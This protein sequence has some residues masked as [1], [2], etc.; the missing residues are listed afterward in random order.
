MLRFRVTARDSK[1]AARTGLLQLGRRV[2]PTP[3]FMPV[4]TLGTVKAVTTEELLELGCGIVLANTY[5][6]WQR[7]GVEVV[8]EHGGLHR[9]MGW[10]GAILTDSGG[11]QVFSLAELREVRP[12]GVE[13][14]SH[15]D[16][17]KLFLT[18][19]LA[20][21]LQR[22]LGSDIVMPLDECV[23]L[24]ADAQTVRRS[25]ELTHQ[26]AVRSKAHHAGGE[27]AL[28][29]IVQGGVFP[30]LRRRSARGLVELDL[31][32]YAIGGLS[33]G[34]AKPEML[35]TLEV[36]TPELPEEKL[37][38]LMG[39]GTPLDIV[40]AV[41]RGVDMFD[42]VMPT[43]NARNGNLF[44]WQGRVAIKNAE[45]RRDRRPL[46]ESCGCPTCRR[47]SRAYLRHLFVSREILAARLNTLH[48]LYFYLDLMRVIRQSIASARFPSLL[49][50]CRA[51][52]APSPAAD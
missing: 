25:V 45:N 47:Y 39:V 21:D 30:E 14:R 48:N 1:T 33:V 40:E 29:G 3:V 35:A 8:A 38:Y 19:E 41:A 11:F 4:G 51:R 46:D 27:Q 28:F 20:L 22:A 9:F 18:P 5:H 49:T 31:D 10:P 7:P 13:F 34:E 17:R 32:G 23:A 26:W 2:I 44:T 42:C 6:L 52:W 43:R 15:V 37:R 16:G 24:P 50:D 12:E 36:V